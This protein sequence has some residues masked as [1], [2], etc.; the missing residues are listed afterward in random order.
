MNDIIEKGKYKTTIFQSFK[1][2]DANMAHELMESSSHIGKI[3][4]DMKG[5]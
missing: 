3:L 5:E 2:K 1:M 4:I